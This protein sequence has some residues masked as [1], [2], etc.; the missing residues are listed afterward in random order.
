MTKTPSNL[1]LIGMPGAGKST[2]GVILA[3]QTARAFVDTDLLIQTAQGRTL[4]QIVDTDGYAAFRRIEEEILLGLSIRNSVIATGG[5]AVYS[6][7]AMTH[8]KSH[9]L[10]IFLDATLATLERRVRDFSTR[11]LARRPNQSFTELFEERIALY[12]RH[13]DIVITC[14]DTTQEQVC[15]R[16]IEGIWGKE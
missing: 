1:V 2:V 16:I 8:L 11:G 10:L 5:S 13:A 4:Q 6:E 7:Q 15:K 9:G 3:K 12:T 14:D